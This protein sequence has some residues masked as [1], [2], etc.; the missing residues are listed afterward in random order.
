MRHLESSSSRQCPTTSS[1]SVRAFFLR[2]LISVAHQ[3]QLRMYGCRSVCSVIVSSHLRLI[4]S[5]Y[6]NS[7]LASLNARE[8][9]RDRN[10]DVSIRFNTAIEFSSNSS[11]PPTPLS[12][13]ALKSEKVRRIRPSLH[14]VLNAHP[15]R[16]NPAIV[17]SSSSSMDVVE[18][19]RMREEN[20]SKRLNRV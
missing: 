15:Q 6:L 5:V 10:A 14:P 9:L 1:S 19:E 20:A 16:Y 12:S 4:F 11:E 2:V 8:V 17:A 7:Y 18:M 13:T 3:F